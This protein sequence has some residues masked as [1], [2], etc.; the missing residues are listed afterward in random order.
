MSI[1]SD[2][3]TVTDIE[4]NNSVHTVDTTTHNIVDAEPTA[5]D[6][7]PT[8]WSNAARMIP[9]AFLFGDRVKPWN[10]LE[11][12]AD[13]AAKLWSL[14]FGFVAFFNKRY[15]AKIDHRIPPCWAEHGPIVEELTTLM[16]ARWH[17]FESPQGSVGGAQYWHSYTLPAFLS[18]IRDWL[19]DDLLSC[20]Q[21][22]HRDHDDDHLESDTSWAM[23]RELIS[24]MDV[25]M[26][27]S[28]TDDDSNENEKRKVQPSVEIPFLNN[29]VNALH[30]SRLRQKT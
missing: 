17:A 8:C 3:E 15:G 11:L 9:G 22:R 24:I 16:F 21:G 18:R 19:G 4:T 27:K 1:I 29:V 13:E 25:A 20:Q 30:S 28:D 6:W 14:L 2:G 26:R 7:I 12:D 10:W 23:R 5:R